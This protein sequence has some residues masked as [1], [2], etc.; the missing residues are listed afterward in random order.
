MRD[1]VL[2]RGFAK[3]SNDNP[4]ENLFYQKYMTQYKTTLISRSFEKS[5]WSFQKS[6]FNLV[7]RSDF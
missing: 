3:S 7:N 4:Y 2:K 5:S 6:Y 1:K